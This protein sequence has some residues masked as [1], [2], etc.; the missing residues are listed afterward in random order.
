MNNPAPK[1]T[2]AVVPPFSYPVLDTVKLARPSKKRAADF[3]DLSLRRASARTCHKLKPGYLDELLWYSAKALELTVQENGYILS[4]RPTPSAG[5]RHPIDILI[6]LDLG[7]PILHYYD[8][9]GHSLS[10]LDLDKRLVRD[11]LVHVQ[12]NLPMMDGTLLWFVAHP[13]RTE[14]KYEFAD[15]LVWRDAGALIQ[16]VQLVAAALGLVSCPTGTLG[17]PFEHKLFGNIG[18]TVAAGGIIVG[19]L[20]L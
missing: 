3:F 5:A 17:T 18:R 19:N 16:Q 8:P 20:D 10:R 6:C 11:F 15:S 1:K 13:D 2:E 9:L 4:H 7:Q 12:Q 14:A